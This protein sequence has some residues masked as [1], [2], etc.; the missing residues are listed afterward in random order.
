MTAVIVDTA[1][2]ARMAAALRRVIA[3]ALDDLDG[4]GSGVLELPVSV[5]WSLES[6]RFDLSDR[7]QVR[8]AYKFVIDAARQPEHLIPYLNAA[9]LKD[10]WD[11]LGLPRRKRAAWEELNPGLRSRPTATAA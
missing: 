9:L 10:V 2:Q 6:P 7:G 3:V 4:P 1:P 5:C 11:D 8:S